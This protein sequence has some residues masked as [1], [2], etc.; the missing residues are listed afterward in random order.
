M[1]VYASDARERHQYVDK[2]L[3]EVRNNLATN[4]GVIE[5]MDANMRTATL[6][7]VNEAFVP[8]FKD[9]VVTIPKSYLDTDATPVLAIRRT[10]TLHLGDGFG[11]MTPAQ[12]SAVKN[13]RKPLPFAEH[14]TEM[15]ALLKTEEGKEDVNAGIS[16]LALGAYVTHLHIIARFEYPD[17]ESTA[18]SLKTDRIILGR[19]ALM[20]LANR[21]GDFIHALNTSGK[22]VHELVHVWQRNQKPLIEPTSNDEEAV[23]AEL[24][25]ELPAYRHAGYYE[26]GL[27]ESGDERYSGNNDVY[28]NAYIEVERQKHVTPEQ[29]Y[30]PDAQFVD[31]LK[32]IGA[33]GHTN[34]TLRANE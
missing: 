4:E 25:I 28:G 10:E 12:I 31:W 29:P 34:L 11:R 16:E 32:K 3:E 21:D 14:L 30:T 20:L 17:P 26:R 7:L 8:N 15:Q 22:L 2:V 9:G 5:R 1:N 33:L 19:S 23:R 18:K 27:F 13:Q 6:T 24:A